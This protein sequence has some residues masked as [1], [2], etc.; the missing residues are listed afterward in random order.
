MGPQ[1]ELDVGRRCHRVAGN[2]ES[3]VPDPGRLQ[4]LR[5]LLEVVPG[6]DSY[7]LSNEE[8]ERRDRRAAKGGRIE[9]REHDVRGLRDLEALQRDILLV[10]QAEADEGELAHGGPYHRASPIRIFG[11]GVIGWESR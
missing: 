4:D 8:L 5:T 11:N 9:F 6:E 3:D 1:T 2:Q 10:E 7:R